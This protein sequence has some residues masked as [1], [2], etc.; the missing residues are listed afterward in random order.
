MQKTHVHSIQSLKTFILQFTNLSVRAHAGTISHI[1][2]I[3]KLGKV[4]VRLYFNRSWLDNMCVYRINRSYIITSHQL[5]ND[6][7]INICKDS[8]FD[9]A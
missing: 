7:N 2:K 3:H 8:F 5:N 4:L 1:F 6:N 9:L